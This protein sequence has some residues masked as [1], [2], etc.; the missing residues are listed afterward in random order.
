MKKINSILL[1]L[2]FSTTIIMAQVNLKNGLVGC[3]PF[4]AN[5]NDQSGNNNNGA[6]NGATLA[7]DRFGKAN[8]AYN[9]DG[10]NAITVD[11]SQFKNQSFSYG[12]WVKLDILPSEGENNCF[13]AIGG[14]GADQLLSVSKSYQAQSSNG[15]NVGGYNAGMPIISNNWDNSTPVI[16]KWY[17][18]V[19]TRDNN[20]IKLYVDGQ[21]IINNSTLTATGGTS[22][23][24]ASESFVTFGARHGGTSQYMQGSLDDIHLYNR[25]INAAEVKALYDGNTPQTITIT[26][27]N[28]APCGGENIIFTANGGSITSKYQWKV[29][30]VNVGTQ[31]TS[32]TFSYNSVNKP[33]DYQVKISVEIT[34]DEICFPNKIASM[35]A[36]FNL[37]NCTPCVNSLLACRPF[38]VTK[39]K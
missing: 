3:Y 20:S 35:D 1:V 30:G 26:S 17:H 23:N 27:N 16:G 7:I 5:A 19:C 4:N 33:T 6:I 38:N 28:A 21:L 15:F 25:A 31:T 39:T 12:V 36:F 8:S 32:N 22:P 10:S 34:D 37:T 29:S 2:L 13:I 11:V 14:P 9:F 24:Y 18:L